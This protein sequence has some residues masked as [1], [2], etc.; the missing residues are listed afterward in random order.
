LGC[1]V[2]ELAADYQGRG[3]LREAHN[4]TFERSLEVAEEMRDLMATAAWSK[5]IGSDGDVIAGPPGTLQQRYKQWNS[6]QTEY[7]QLRNVYEE[8]TMQGFE[9]VAVSSRKFGKR[10][11]Y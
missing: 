7:K 2:Q 9:D 6:L 5:V 8:T 3:V 1:E 11:W 4:I 10:P